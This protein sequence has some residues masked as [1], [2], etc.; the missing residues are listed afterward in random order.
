MSN[1]ERKA[2]ILKGML[3][4]AGKNYVCPACFKSNSQASDLRNHLKQMKEAE[5]HKGL[6]EREEAKFRYSYETRWKP[7][8]KVPK[9]DLPRERIS[10]FA[11]DVVVTKIASQAEDFVQSKIQI[12]L[13]ITVKSGMTHV[14]PECVDEDMQYFNKMVDFDHHCWEK[15]DRTHMDLLSKSPA[16]FLPTYLKAMGLAEI[17]ELPP[18]K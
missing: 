2:S 10:A 11:R 7:T 13:K 9:L 6:S 18:R 8:D 12:H 1:D 3:I 17:E 5:D 4:K 16:I 14:C 15:N